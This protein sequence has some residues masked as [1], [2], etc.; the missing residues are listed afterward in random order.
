MGD[1]CP[2]CGSTRSRDGPQREGLR[3]A[4]CRGCGSGYLVG[5]SIDF[6]AYY[7]DYDPDLVL[8]LPPVLARRYGTMLERIERIAPGRRLLEVGCGNGHFLAVA[9]RRGWEVSGVELSRAHVDRARARGLDVVYGDLGDDALWSDHRFDALVAIEVLEHVPRPLDLL[10]AAA[11]RLAPGGALFLTTPNFGSV[12]RRLLG[13]GWSVLDPE[14]VALASPAGLASA[15]RRAGFTVVRMESRNLYLSEYRRLWSG[16]AVAA[17]DTTARAEATAELRDR[18]EGSALLR[19]A[20]AVANAALS[21]TG[22]GEGLEC[23]A[24]RVGR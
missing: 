14:H 9:E 17:G 18:I 23:L 2:F 15:L 24:R 4:I 13:A 22:W 11:D 21:L 12:T 19:G 7:E 10:R 8:E 5:E 6:R 1:G 3:Y 20:K 16:R